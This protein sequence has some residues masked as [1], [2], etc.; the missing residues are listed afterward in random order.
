MSNALTHLTSSWTFSLEYPAGLSLVSALPS[1]GIQS[2]KGPSGSY[3]QA[4]C[5]PDQFREAV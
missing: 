5:K 2:S 1:L 4:S 3:P